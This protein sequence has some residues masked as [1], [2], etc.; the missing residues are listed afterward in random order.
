MK[1]TSGPVKYFLFDTETGGRTKECCLLTLY[2]QILNENFDI[3]E[4]IDLK[5]KPE[6]GIYK[7]T[8]EALGINKIVVSDHDSHAVKESEASFLF[9]NFVGRHT[10]YGRITPI[11]HNVRFD[12]KFAKAHIFSE[13]DKYFDYHQI[14][15]A[16]LAKFLQQA[17]FLPKSLDCSLDSLIQHYGIAMNPALRHTAKGDVEATYAVY[18]KMLSAIKTFTSSTLNNSV[19]ISP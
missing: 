9:K 8:A 10:Y 4:E 1:K 6:D 16:S 18:M 15:T 7:F 2:G 11:G 17:G 13:W 5:I 14:D 12:V 3:L 19:S